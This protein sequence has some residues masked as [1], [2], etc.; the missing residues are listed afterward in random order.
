MAVNMPMSF[1]GT[2][3][4]IEA[5]RKTHYFINTGGWEDGD[6]RCGGCDC[7]PWGITAEWPCGIDPPRVTVGTDDANAAYAGTPMATAFAD[8]A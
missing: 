3:E 4:E 8:A 7:R 6:Y 2:A 1:P 5:N